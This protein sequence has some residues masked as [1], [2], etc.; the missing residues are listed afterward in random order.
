MK[1]IF[2]LL[3]LLSSF[4]F[5]AIDESKT[6]IYFANGIIIDMDVIYE[7]ELSKVITQNR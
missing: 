6:D 3:I 4:V 7:L 5:S 2:I 1:K